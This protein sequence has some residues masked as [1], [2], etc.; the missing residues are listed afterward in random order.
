MKGPFF[1][2]NRINFDILENS[3]FKDVDVAINAVIEK[4]NVEIKEKIEVFDSYWI[5][6]KIN[7]QYEICIR[8]HDP[9]GLTI[10][11]ENEQS[12]DIVTEIANYFQKEVFN[13][14]EDIGPKL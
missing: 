9:I 14:I 6:A 10:Y 11:A 7:Q 5:V 2:E 3:N 8:H 1:N 12:N 4:Y 13:E